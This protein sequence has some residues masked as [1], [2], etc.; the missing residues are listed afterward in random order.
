MNTPGPWII[1]PRDCGDNI[2]TASKPHRRIA[3]TYGEDESNARLI[4][5]APELLAAL[6]RFLPYIESGY[7]AAYPGEV[8]E[9]DGYV[10]Q[11]IKDL[12]AL[13]AKATA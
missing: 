7:N 10:A 9:K 12:R 6:Q 2:F 1:L 3:N 11:E 8:Y 13:I 5:A 4:A